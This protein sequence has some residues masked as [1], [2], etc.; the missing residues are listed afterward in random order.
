[1]ITAMIAYAGFVWLML[2]NLGTYTHSGHI[3]SSI[4]A[5][6]AVAGGALAVEV[7]QMLKDRNV[8]LVFA[9][10]QRLADHTVGCAIAAVAHIAWV[11]A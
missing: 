8:L 2:E 7:W 5:V 3:F 4:A 1:M 10:S 11:V 9:A 6:L